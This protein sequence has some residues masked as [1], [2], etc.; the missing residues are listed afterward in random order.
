MAAQVAGGIWMLV[1]GTMGL[2]K[3]TGLRLPRAFMAMLLSMFFQVQTAL[4][5]HLLGLM[6]K[7]MLK[8]LIFYA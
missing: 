6:S 7:V 4:A 3:L 5:L 8:A 1:W 2:R